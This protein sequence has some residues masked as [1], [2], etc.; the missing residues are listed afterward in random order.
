MNKR[1]A[2][3]YLLFILFL[4]IAWWEFSPYIG[5]LGEI[6]QYRNT[7]AYWWIGIALLLQTVQYGI[8]GYFIRELFRILGIKIGLQ[9]TVRIS[10][11]DIF[12]IRLVPVGKFGS[13]A[14]FIY[15]Y[16]KLGV[17]TQFIVY[18]NL[19]F[20]F[21]TVFLQIF[22]FLL[23]SSLIHSATFPVPLHTYLLEAIAIA[24]P[25]LLLLLILVLRVGE[26]RRLLNTLLHKIPWYRTLEKNLVTLE[27]FRK[28]MRKRLGKFLGLAVSKDLLYYLCDVII[29][30][31]CFLSFHTFI[32]LPLIV[33]AYIVSLIA[34][35]VSL[36]PGG[37]GATDAALGVIFIS[38]KVN[39]V[40][41]VG[42]I[43]LYRLVSFLY[44]FLVGALSYYSLRHTL[45][46]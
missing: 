24:S 6:Y 15:F 17:S 39:P 16:R 40:V 22:I 43:L 33:F 9:D 29:L 42:V 2:F 31:S 20:G 45:R 14:A 18:L 26:F 19:V 13:L 34:G 23:S 37:L 44:P 28:L 25:V 5:D 30:E 46:A 10:A 11:L 38:A 27:K 35:T 8:D 1:K 41:T 4:V 36:L 12:A 21:I 3:Q 32:S 7:L